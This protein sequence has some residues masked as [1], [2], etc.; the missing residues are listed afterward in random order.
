MVE[1][2]GIMV[3]EVDM[4]GGMVDTVEEV[5]VVIIITGRWRWGVWWRW[6]VWWGVWWPIWILRVSRANIGIVW[7]FSSLVIKII[8]CKKLV[9]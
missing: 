9:S 8:M 4:V 6:R 3:E 2:M 1:V 5:E 7:R